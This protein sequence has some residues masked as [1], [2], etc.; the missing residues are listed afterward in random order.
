MRTMEFCL[1]DPF[2]LSCTLRSCGIAV[3]SFYQS[4]TASGEVWLVSCP[5]CFFGSLLFWLQ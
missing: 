3:C 5:L 1:W 2:R 4:E